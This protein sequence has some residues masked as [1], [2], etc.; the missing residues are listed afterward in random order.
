MARLVLLGAGHAHMTVMARIP[1]MVKA[2]HEVTVVGP[3]DRHYYSGMGPGMLG[4]EYTDVDISFPVRRMVEDRGG[5]FVLDRAEEILYRDKKVRLA[6]GE[7]VAYDVLSCNTGSYVPSPMC[8]AGTEDVFPVKPIENL[9]RGR[10]RILEIASERPVS[11]GVCGGGPA[12]LEV[13]GNAA[14]AARE[15]G[16]GAR[17]SVYAG[18]HFL[19]RMP[20]RVADAC[21]QEVR[22]AG[23]N[24]VE[25]TYVRSVTTGRVELEDER[26]FG[27]DVIFLA[28][29]V[30]PSPLFASSD[31]PMGLDGGLLVND[32]LQCVGVPEV[33]G[34]GDCIWYMPRPLDKVGVY[35]VRENPVLADNL[36]AQMEGRALRSF[37]PG[38]SYLLI[39]NVG[40]GRAVLHKSG[41]LFSGRF[42]FRIKDFIDRK[43]MKQFKPSYEGG[44]G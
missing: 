27:H 29:G 11:I 34:G 44:K 15:A 31:L 23:I 24:V 9:L 20:S 1:E 22:R 18:S 43:F 39:F 41:L 25:G 10:E 2:G 14:A 8:E 42:A 4:G 5:T 37:D 16:Q 7:T 21:R 19:S 36:L 35:A 30:K 12:A 13:A 33:F 40:G 6:S 17:V 32:R 28:L 3:L 26:V 38:G